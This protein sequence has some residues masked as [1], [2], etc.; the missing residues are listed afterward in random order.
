[1][2]NKLEKIARKYFN[3]FS[4]KNIHELKDMFS[5]D[6]KLRD[7]DLE[8]NGLDNVIE[9]ISKIFNSSEYL[10]IK[11][12]ELYFDVNVVVAELEIIVNKV[13]KI[14]VVDIIKFDNKSKITNIKAFKG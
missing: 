3:L 12:I 11:I 7:W 10:T 14:K 5:N 6:I 2:K 1:M 13:N 9:A 4:K 8:V